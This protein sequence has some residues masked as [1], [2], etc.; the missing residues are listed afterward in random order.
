[1]FTADN[2]VISFFA[3]SKLKINSS[4]ASNLCLFKRQWSSVNP[5][6][7]TTFTSLIVPFYFLVNV[8]PGW[9]DSHFVS[10]AFV[11]LCLLC[12]GSSRIVMEAV[13]DVTGAVLRPDE[14]IAWFCGVKRAVCPSLSAKMGR[15]DW[16]RTISAGIWR[17]SG[18]IMLWSAADTLTRFQF[19]ELC[20]EV[21]TYLQR[22]VFLVASRQS[23]VCHTTLRAVPCRLCFNVIY[24]VLNRNNNNNNNNNNIYW[25]QM[26]RH[27]VA[28]VI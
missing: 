20:E 8:T 1:M 15:L 18:A 25:L 7:H 26:G 28:V 5:Q 11:K 24:G 4:S 22:C 23:A 19:L 6:V 2:L 9:L 3:R 10:F 21:R 12:R 13:A 27:P 17:R 14:I 16:P